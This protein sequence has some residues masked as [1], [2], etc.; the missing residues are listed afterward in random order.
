[1]VILVY[2]DSTILALIVCAPDTTLLHDDEKCN[3]S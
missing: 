2:D 3:V 1:M